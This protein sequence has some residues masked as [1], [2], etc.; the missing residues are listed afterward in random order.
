[1]ELASKA[2]FVAF[3]VT[4]VTV[5]LLGGRPEYRRD[6]SCEVMPCCAVCNGRPANQFNE[7]SGVETT[8]PPFK[9]LVTGSNPVRPTI[10]SRA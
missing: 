5:F 9:Q 4:G 1:M 3:S 7:N 6:Q 10:N 2:W 8:S